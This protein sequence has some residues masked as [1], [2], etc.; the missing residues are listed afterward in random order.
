MHNL[1]LAAQQESWRLVERFRGRYNLSPEDVLRLPDDP[2]VRAQLDWLRAVL[3]ARGMCKVL[4]IGSGCG[5]AARA[6]AEDGHQV[7]AT[8][9]LDDLQV[10]LGRAVRQQDQ[11]G[12]KFLCVLTGAE[13]LPFRAESF[14][15]VFCFATLRH[16]VD[17]ERV[18][19]E[20]SRVLHPGGLFVALQEPFR[21]GLTTQAQRFQD[22]FTYLL[23]R[24][25]L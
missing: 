5:W 14:D 19:Q 11:T 12:S 24:W 13:R 2:G 17:L 9:I 10:G 3:R 15:C 21:G 8:D 23:A 16:I 4:E 20:V 1:A 22:C 18:F 6:L 7:V 25:W